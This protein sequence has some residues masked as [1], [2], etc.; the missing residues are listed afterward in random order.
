[1]LQQVTYQEAFA[2]AAL[3]NVDFQHAEFL[4]EGIENGSPSKNDVSPLWLQPRHFT[5]LLQGQGS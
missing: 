4:H 3:A 1:M 5:T 2:Q